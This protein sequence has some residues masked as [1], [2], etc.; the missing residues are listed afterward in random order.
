MVQASVEAIKALREQ[1]SAGIMDCKRAL[2]EAGGD[3][4]QAA[5]LLRQKGVILAGKKAGRD[6]QEGAVDCYI[7]TGN[8]VGALVEVNCETDFVA[9]TPEFK[10]LVHN[11]A[12][13]VAAMSPRFLDS[14][15]VPDEFTVNPEEACLLEQPFIKDP[16]KTIRDLITEMV[17]Q[18]GEN[19]RVRRFERFALGE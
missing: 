4:A 19:I 15:A 3:V 16:S 5:E 10:D 6:T 18:V 7:H 9:R 14:E 13:Q 17:G 2:E 8:R 1:T 12:M 11:L